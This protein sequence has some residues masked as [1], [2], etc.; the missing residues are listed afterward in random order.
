MT[1]SMKEYLRRF[2]QLSFSSE[3]VSKDLESMNHLCVTLFF[4][5]VD[6]KT[7]FKDAMITLMKGKT[8][9]DQEHALDVCER[10][11]K[12]WAAESDMLAYLYGYDCSLFFLLL[13]CLFFY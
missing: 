7:Y 9:D 13:S 11:V 1:S 12:F 10:A 5:F 4:L 6:Y 2:L 3:V 8:K